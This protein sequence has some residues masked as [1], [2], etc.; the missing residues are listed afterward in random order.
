M[1]DGALPKSEFTSGEIV[2]VFWRVFFTSIFISIFEQM[3][4]KKE[5]C[6]TF[7][8]IV[9]LKSKLTEY[10][11]LQEKQIKPSQNCFTI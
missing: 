6:V 3:I 7:K 11:N 5:I 9:F 2:C 8:V 1:S 10:R 4:Y